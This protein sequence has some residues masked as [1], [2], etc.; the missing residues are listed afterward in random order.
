MKL[1]FVNGH[2]NT[3]GVEKSLINLLRTIDYSQHTV[4]LLLFEGLG[5]YYEDL[6]GEV[7]VVLCDL[8]PTYGSFFST[9]KKCFI[10]KDLRSI[11][12]KIILTL[13]SH[14]SK[15]FMRLIRIR[16]ITDSEYDCA[17]AYRLGICSD[18]V[19][20]GVKAKKK[21]AWWHHGEFNYSSGQVTD[22]KK[23]LKYT[24]QI[25]C[26][27]ESS[28]DLIKPYFKDVVSS[29]T[30]LPNMI[31]SRDITVL[32]DKF[33][34]YSSQ[35]NVFVTV[36][37]LSEEKHMENAVLAAKELTGRGFEDF[38]WYLIGEGKEHHRIENLIK[39]NQLDNKVI[40]L[41]NQLNPYPYIADAD[42]Y[43]HTSYV[44]SQG[45][46]VLEAL[47]LGRP[48]VVTDSAGVHEY[49]INRENGLLVSQGYKY[50]AEGIIELLN[51]RE[52]MDHIKYNS[53]CPDMF[54][55]KNVIKMFEKLIR[56]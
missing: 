13:S 2:L 47:T 44:E 56:S 1:L 25:V 11:F 12:L 33:H 27:S 15:E 22:W 51:N 55:D 8:H 4:D 45:L 17:I 21:L 20:Y 32:G 36:G 41:G 16:G 6:P 31:I 43:V 54:M 14:I 3:G 52:L 37:R 39:E 19:S 42:I 26:V 24:D 30:V 5:D 50:L 29:I 48:C 10:S 35:N 49:I 7:N 18:F 38:V 9:I 46:S 23:S 34:P 28:K 53:K 40:M